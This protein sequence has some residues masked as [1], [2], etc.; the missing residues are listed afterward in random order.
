MANFFKKIFKFLVAG[1]IEEK[2]IT[3]QELEEAKA[4]SAGHPEILER[5]IKR[6][7]DNYEAMIGEYREKKLEVRR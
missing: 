1:N 4:K 3:P 5:V 7:I 6:R 2:R